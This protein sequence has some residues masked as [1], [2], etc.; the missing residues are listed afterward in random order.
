MKNIV[1]FHG[2]VSLPEGISHYEVHE[3]NS[4][5]PLIFDLPNLM[6]TFHFAFTRRFPGRFPRDRP[7]PV[8]KLIPGSRRSVADGQT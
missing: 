4:D 6:V 3:K 2:D 5:F 1:T 7:L 8:D